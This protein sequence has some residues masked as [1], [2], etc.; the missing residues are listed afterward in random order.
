MWHFENKN[1]QKAVNRE[2]LQNHF[3]FRKVALKNSS[4]PAYINNTF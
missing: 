1:R 4:Y 2:Q 3:V